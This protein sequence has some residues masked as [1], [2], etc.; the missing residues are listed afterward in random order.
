MENRF[1]IPVKL[2]KDKGYTQGNVEDD[3][4][5]T[6]LR[7]VQDINLRTILGTTFFKRLLTGVKDNDLTVDEVTLIDDYIAP[8]L[9]AKVDHRITNHLAFEIRSKTVGTADDQ[10]IKTSDTGNMLK[11]QDDLRSDAN[12]YKNTLIGYLKD[13]CLLFDEY[14]NYICNF[15]NVRPDKEQGGDVAVSFI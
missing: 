15:E 1:I 14:N 10:Y 8:Y 11:L 6:T 3:I 12:S 4:I 9:I 2:I 7:R 5:T 13:N